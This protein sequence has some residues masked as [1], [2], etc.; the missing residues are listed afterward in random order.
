MVDAELDCPFRSTPCAS[1]ERDSAGNRER[2][3]WLHHIPGDGHSDCDNRDVAGAG[4]STNGSCGLAK[5][6]ATF[7]LGIENPLVAVEHCLRARAAFEGAGL[8]CA[9]WGHHA[10]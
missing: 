5:G 6:T 7:Y 8:A 9:G 2:W 4:C 3:P 10:R 1:P